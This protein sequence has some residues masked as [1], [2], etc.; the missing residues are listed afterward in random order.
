LGL[1]K[2][3]IKKQ[4]EWVDETAVLCHAYALLAQ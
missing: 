4:A 3:R 1:R 2:I